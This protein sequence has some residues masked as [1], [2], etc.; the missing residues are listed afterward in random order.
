MVLSLHGSGVSPRK[1]A[2]E[3]VSK[4]TF[5]AAFFAKLD[6]IDAGKREWA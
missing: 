1:N 3:N 2:V 5:S 4:S 6:I